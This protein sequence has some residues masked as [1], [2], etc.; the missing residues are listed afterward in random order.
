[1]NKMKRLLFLL[2]L[3]IA[4]VVGVSSCTENERAKNYGGKEDITL[5]PSEQFVNA[6]WKD[7]DLWLITKDTLTNEYI[8]REKSSY[9]VWEGEIR[10]QAA[11][12]EAFPKEPEDKPEEGKCG[13]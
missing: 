3:L 9:G 12:V 6:T 7:N 2:M 1:M 8:M 4:I 11:I 13:E 5:K 10:I